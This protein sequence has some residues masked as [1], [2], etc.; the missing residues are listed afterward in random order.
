MLVNIHRGELDGQR[1]LK[2]ASYDVMWKPA[3][4]VSGSGHVGIS[5]FLPELKG[6]PLVAHGGGDDGFLTYLIFS[7]TRRAGVVMMVNTDRAAIRKIW[8]P[9]LLMALGREEK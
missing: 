3:A 1:I 2:P 5:W 8:E 9:A 7:P 6:E 4:A